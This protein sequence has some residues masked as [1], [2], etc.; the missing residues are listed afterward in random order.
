MHMSHPQLVE[1]SKVV[2][3]A[4]VGV[5]LR[6]CHAVRKRFTWSLHQDA[7]RSA[8]TVQSEPERAHARWSTCTAFDPPFWQG[9]VFGEHA[10]YVTT[11]TMVL[12]RA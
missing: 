2:A 12:P 1:H 6:R 9:Q 8:E 10:G 7:R 3:D 5:D 11:F 4:D